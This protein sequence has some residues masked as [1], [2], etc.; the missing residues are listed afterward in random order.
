MDI[1]PLHST[2]ATSHNEPF[3]RWFPYLEGYSPKFV[4]A[5]LDNI[6]PQAKR[7]LD[8]F[9]G[10]GTTAFVCAQRGLESLICEI[11]PIMQYIFEI[12]CHI[13]K[14]DSYSRNDI[15]KR[16]L[17]LKHDLNDQL[18]N[19]QE[20]S[21][22]KSNYDSCFGGSRFFTEEVLSIILKL[23][24][25]EKALMKESAILANLFS[26]CVIASLVP[27]SLMKRAGDLRKKTPKEISSSL[28]INVIDVIYAKIDQISDDIRD[29]SYQVNANIGLL[30]PNAKDIGG[31]DITFDTVITSPPYP[32]GTN[33]FRNTKIELWYAGF[34]QSDEDLADLRYKAVT[35]GINDV[36]RKKVIEPKIDAVAEIV[37]NLKKVE[38]DWRIS[39]LI[40]T[41]FGEME[42]IFRNIAEKIDTNGKLIIDIGDS[43]YAGVHVKVDE[44][45]IKILESMSFTLQDSIKLRTRFSK[46]GSRLSQT[47][48]VLQ[49]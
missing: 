49:K 26:I 1:N 4:E 10:N 43:N 13:L 27:S 35:A 32:N 48:L 3:Q 19:F 44:I 46:N 23:K 7:V 11:N 36:T 15:S 34:L 17:S 37:D 41:H 8:P 12:K 38:Y 25:Y 24:S 20:D 42:D 2:Y 22:L 9:G 5:I 31:Y 28:H 6:T 16:L 47:L 33:Y 18:S 40:S 39:S 21:E 30:T 45:Y 14:M 29:F